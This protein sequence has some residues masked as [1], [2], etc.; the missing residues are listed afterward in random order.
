ML[1]HVFAQDKSDALQLR[2]EN[3][4]AH[5]AW[6][7]QHLDVVK[8]AGPILSEPDNSL[9]GSVLVIEA[10]DRATLEAFLAEDP[11]A[12]AGLFERVEIH[13]FRWVINAP[14]SL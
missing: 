10:G 14:D 9:M 1:F 13:P 11:Y 3:R 2:M 5:L 4:E 8:M 7:R 12:K 6:V